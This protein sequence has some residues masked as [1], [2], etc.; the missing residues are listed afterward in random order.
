M[1]V[2][3]QIQIQDGK[4][5]KEGKGERIREKIRVGAE[6]TNLVKEKNQRRLLQQLIL[7]DLSP[8]R[9]RILLEEENIKNKNRKKNQGYDINH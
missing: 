6:G 4:Q 3:P 7:A 1:T 9:N 8:K 5:E 2:G